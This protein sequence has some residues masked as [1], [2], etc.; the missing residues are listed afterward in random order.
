MQTIKLFLNELLISSN[1]IQFKNTKNYFNLFLQNNNEEIFKKYFNKIYF[2][3]FKYFYLGASLQPG[4]I[5]NNNSIES[6]HSKIKSKHFF[7]KYSSVSY[8][9]NHGLNEILKLSEDSYDYDTTIKNIIPNNMIEKAFK[10][11]NSNST[12]KQ[13]SNEDENEDIFYVNKYKYSNKK[14]TKNRI[15]DYFKFSN[16]KLEEEKYSNLTLDEFIYKYHSLHKIIHSEGKYS[17]DCASN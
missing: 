2:K 10:Y 5:G 1:N 11:I 13:K 4:V 16:E 7:T 8:F 14:I 9:L 15:E 6:F 17:C 3:Q 12:I